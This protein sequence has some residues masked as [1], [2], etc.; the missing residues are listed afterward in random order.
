[1]STGAV[2]RNPFRIAGVLDIAGDRLCL[3]AEFILGVIDN[4]HL[5]EVDDEGLLLRTATFEAEQ[6]DEARTALAEWRAESTS[7]STSDD[8]LDRYDFVVPELRR[9]VGGTPYGEM[10]REQVRA[11]QGDGSVR[12]RLFGRDDLQLDDRRSVVNLGA[13]TGSSACGAVADFAEVF[14]RWVGSEVLAVRG[15]RHGVARVTIADDGGNEYAVLAVDEA[16][17]DGRVVRP[18]YL[19]SDRVGDALALLDEW[20]PESDDAVGTEAVDPLDRITFIVPELRRFVEGTPYAL[21]AVF[22]EAYA[23]GDEDGLAWFYG[24]DDLVVENRMSTVNSGTHVG[25]DARAVLL[26]TRQYFP[27][28]E[29]SEILAVRGTRFG[30]SAAR[31]ATTTATDTR[32]SPSRRLRRMASSSV[33]SSSTPTAI[34]AVELLDEWYVSSPGAIGREVLNAGTSMLHSIHDPAPAASS[35]AGWPTTW[36]ST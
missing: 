11:W 30:V 9:V 20:Y 35:S 22:I 36:W 12:R 28:P 32:C 31:S 10:C 3:T 19:D 18:T 23:N 14:T 4:L 33:R 6:L 29:R 26:V 25:S 17:P 13:A 7:T 15:T 2:P 8:P 21:L 16:D 27:N 5:I 34:E 24:R 1:M